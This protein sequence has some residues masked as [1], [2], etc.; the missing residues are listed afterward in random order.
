MQRRA[1][2]PWPCGARGV[3]QRAGAALAREV[4]GARSSGPAV[5]FCPGS[6]CRSH[7]AGAL[8]HEPGASLWAPIVGRCCGCRRARPPGWFQADGPKAKA[9]RGGEPGNSA[10]P[11]AEVP[12]QVPAG[13]GCGPGVQL[14][15]L[16]HAARAAVGVEPGGAGAQLPGARRIPRRGVASE[17]DAGRPPL[18]RPCPRHR[19]L[20]PWPH[21]ARCVAGRAGRG[22]RR[23]SGGL[24]LVPPW[25]PPR[26]GG[27]GLADQAGGAG[28]AGRPGRPSARPPP[29]PRAGRV[30]ARR[31]PNPRYRTAHGC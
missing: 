29:R 27:P 18:Q 16:A 31:R 20:S 6:R 1:S 28:S 21:S 10:E 4:C 11:P 26:P 5:D 24:C 12:C 7:G 14:E 30:R 9:A 13:G 8:R 17:D 2:S 19:R 3:R 15:E 25:R 22:R 23:A